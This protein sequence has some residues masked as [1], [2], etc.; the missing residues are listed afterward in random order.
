MKTIQ[1]LL[2][3]LL[4]TFMLSAQENNDVKKEKTEKVKKEKTKHERNDQV[5]TIFGDHQLAHGGYVSFDM[6]YSNNILGRNGLLLGARGA[7]IVDHWFSMGMGGYGLVSGIQ[8]DIG[9]S[10][11][12]PQSLRLQMGYGGMLLELTPLPR[13]PVH[14]TFPVLLGIGGC[15]FYNVIDNN[16]WNYDVYLPEDT[17]V[18]FIAQPEALVE[19][20]LLKH[21][22]R[23]SVV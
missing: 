7:W 22:D 23:K 5:H 6:D 13:F 11:N 17:D 9:W 2:V 10:G 8:K 12:D 15:A 18:F 21:I 1:I 3:L 20:N 14:V 19:V 16:N 4:A